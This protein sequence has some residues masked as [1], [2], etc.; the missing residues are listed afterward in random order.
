MKFWEWNHIFQFLNATHGYPFLRILKV[1][2][3]WYGFI[4]WTVEDSNIVVINALAVDKD[5]YN[6][7][8]EETLL[9]NLLNSE[10][11]LTT[12]CSPKKLVIGKN[13]VSKNMMK[14]QMKMIANG[15]ICLGGR[16]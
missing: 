14:L 2:K 16:G 9:Q 7:G 1:R 4:S 10:F 3:K 11:I 5:Y 12:I 13:T 6:K 8:V 15:Y